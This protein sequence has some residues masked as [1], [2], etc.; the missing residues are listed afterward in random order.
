[1]TCRSCARALLFAGAV[2]LCFADL[3]SKGD[4]RRAVTV[5]GFPAAG[6]A[7]SG[8]RLL[9]VLRLRGGGRGGGGGG[10]AAG[11]LWG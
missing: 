2:L 9:S 7:G 11:D 8:D 4:Q 10:G 6:A 1:M 5:V 3:P